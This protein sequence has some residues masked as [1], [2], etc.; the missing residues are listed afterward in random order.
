M[1][2]VD[3]KNTQSVLEN[4]RNVGDGDGREMTLLQ[5]GA[6]LQSIDT[7]Y[8]ST[9]NDGYACRRRMAIR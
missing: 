1:A 9:F 7:S 8:K 2:I 3:A 5:T 6:L 4:A